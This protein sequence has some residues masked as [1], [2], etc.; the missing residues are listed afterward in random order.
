MSKKVRKVKKKSSNSEYN[1]VARMLQ[2]ACETAFRAGRVRHCST[3]AKPVS[4][5]FTTVRAKLPPN[6]AIEAER[7]MNEELL[8]NPRTW[9]YW[10]AAFVDGEE[11]VDVEVAV[12]TISDSVLGELTNV[13]PLIVYEAIESADWLEGKV[14]SGWAWYIAPTEYNDF[15]A[16][17]DALIKY[18][19]EGLD[20][21]NQDKRV[22]VASG[23]EGYRSEV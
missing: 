14:I 15:N 3:Q 23:L 10:V 9:H 13:M 5:I 8:H 11:V 1:R 12:G 7:L 21:L 17:S 22:K 20:V 2:S 16:S 4:E 18:F 19:I 6:L